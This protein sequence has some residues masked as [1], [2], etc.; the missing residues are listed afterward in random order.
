MTARRRPLASSVALLIVLLVGLLPTSVEAV[1]TPAG[2]VLGAVVHHHLTVSGI[3][4]A[5][6]AAHDLHADAALS[7]AAVAG[8]LLLAWAVRRRT[9]TA[10]VP[11]AQRAPGSR[12]PPRVG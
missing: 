6:A 1:G 4:R 2:P 8:L 9:Y 5:E 11:V 7:T 10:L 3:V 12:D